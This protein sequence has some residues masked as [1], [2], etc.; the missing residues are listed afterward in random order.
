MAAFDL[1]L[2]NLLGIAVYLASALVAAMTAV[3]T[4]R[5]APAGPSLWLVVA[6]VFVGLALFRLAGAEDT[7]R[8]ALRGLLVEQREYGERRVF[9]TGAVVICLLAVGIGAFLY[10]PRMVQWPLWLAMTAASLGVLGVLY[11]LRLISLHGVDRLLYASVGPVH[12]NHVLE[13]L[14]IAAIW[15]AAWDCRRSALGQGRGHFGKV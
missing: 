14:P 13:L 6:A 5:V 12:F 2:A 4:R 10:V 8:Q 15:F 9:Q 3:Q 1:G 7:I 11:A